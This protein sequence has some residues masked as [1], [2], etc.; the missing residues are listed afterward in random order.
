MERPQI[1]GRREAEALGLKYYF[2]GK[3]CRRAGHVDLRYVENCNCMECTRERANAKYFADPEREHERNKKRYAA[4]PTPN[5]SAAWQRDHPVE[6]R[7][8]KAKWAKEN[9]ESCR[10]KCRR[11]RARISGGGGSHTAKEIEV[12]AERQNHLCAHP[13]C[14]K[15]IRRK[16]HAD[17]IVPLALG[18]SN[19]IAN[20]QLLCPPCNHKKSDKHPVEWAQQNGMLL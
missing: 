15:S 18:G 6:S 4:N 7:A 13:W 12:L 10:A 20:I 2:T 8:H 11:R 14:G 9:P 3:P 1:I 16:R 19:N 5:R 17:H